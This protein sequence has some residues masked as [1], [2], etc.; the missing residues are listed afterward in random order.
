[1]NTREHLLIC[2]SE[3]CAEVSQ[4]VSKAL[5]F[6]LDEIQPGQHKTNADRIVVELADLLAV[7]TL[8]EREG[9]FK[10]HGDHFLDLVEMKR[11]KLATF[12]QY[13]AECGTLEP[14][15]A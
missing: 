11:V 10:A 1:M 5:R 6:G 7:V 9:A 2:L 12:M 13:A 8:L 3:E 14:L 15:P 4:R